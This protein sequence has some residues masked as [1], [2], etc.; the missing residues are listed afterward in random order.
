MRLVAL[1]FDN[2]VQVAQNIFNNLEEGGWVEIQDPDLIITSPDG[3]HEG[4]CRSAPGSNVDLT[5]KANP[6]A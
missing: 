4:T 2:P 1:C 6:L 3:S 5:T